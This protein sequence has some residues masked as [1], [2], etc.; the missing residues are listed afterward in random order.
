VWVDE[1]QTS[2]R[3]LELHNDAVDASVPA[4][5]N[6]AVI[7]SAITRGHTPSIRCVASGNGLFG[8]RLL[9]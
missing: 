2:I 3:S 4:L 5:V 8:L 1:R 9:D 7:K 6:F